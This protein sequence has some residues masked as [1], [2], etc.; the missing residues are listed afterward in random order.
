MPR[1]AVPRAAGGAWRC[2]LFIEHARTYDVVNTPEQ[3]LAAA[4]AF[5]EFQRL[6]VDLPGRRLNETIPFFHHTRRRFEA[7]QRAVETLS[8]LRRG[9]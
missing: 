9:S 2:Y 8:G 5:G 4:R 7:L 1:G 6:L 3:A